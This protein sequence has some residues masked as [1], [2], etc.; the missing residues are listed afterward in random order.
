M[1]FPTY[2]VSYHDAINIVKYSL[3]DDSVAYQSKILAIKKISEMETHNSVTKTELV[4][5]LRWIFFHYD[6][7]G[8]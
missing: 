3:D 4:N 2:N 5:A 8:A 1:P 6:F 7:E